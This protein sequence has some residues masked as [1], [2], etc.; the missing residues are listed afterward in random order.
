MVVPS[1]APGQSGAF[2][3]ATPGWG[4]KP[5]VRRVRP[6]PHATA[7]ASPPRVA[8]AVEAV[9]APVTVSPARAAPASGHGRTWAFRGGGAPRATISGAGSGAVCHARTLRR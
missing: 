5:S 6:H 8:V 7:C 4:G 3:L 2:A 9:G 1:T